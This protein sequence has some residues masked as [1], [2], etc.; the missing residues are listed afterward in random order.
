MHTE[1]NYLESILK[2]YFQKNI[3]LYIDGEELKSGVFM[4]Y[5]LL[6]YSNNYFL[7]FHIKGDKKI[8][9][10][11]IPYPFATEEYEK[12]GLLYMDYRIV[13]LCK[14]NPKLV[15]KIENAANMSSVSD[16]KFYNKILEIQFN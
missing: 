2:K 16:N 3:S 8:D 14:N 6:I 7:E 4:L 15:K 9:I 11:K 12:D 1:E 10:I 5:T 13:T